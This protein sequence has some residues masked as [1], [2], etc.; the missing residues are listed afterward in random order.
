MKA[1]LPPLPMVVL[2]SG[3]GSNLQAFIDQQQELGIRIAAVVSNC[4]GAFGLQRAMRAGIPAH[5]LDHRQYPDRDHFDRALTA[6][7]DSHDPGLVVLAGFMRILT[8][9]TVEHY[10]GRM[11]NIHPSLLPRHKGLHTHR[12]ALAAGDSEHG[13]TVHFVTAELDAGAAVIQARIPVHQGETEDDLQR[14]VQEQERLVYPEA[15]RWFASG[16]LRLEEGIALLDGRPLP[17]QGMTY[18]QP[19]TA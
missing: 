16:R 3:Q 2:I 11:L 18:R 13:A 10:Q 15:V 9:A 6:L 12:R 19:E 7:V 8:P 4:P 5:T 1:T 14:R 17:P